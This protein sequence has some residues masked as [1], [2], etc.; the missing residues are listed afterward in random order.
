MQVLSTEFKNEASG[1]IEQACVV[2]AT[3]QL[4][5]HGF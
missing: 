2:R 1:L 5:L 3:R 4:G